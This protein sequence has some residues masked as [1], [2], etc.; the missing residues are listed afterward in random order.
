MGSVELSGIQML[1][2]E[3]VMSNVGVAVIVAVVLL[4]LYVAAALTQFRQ[5]A[6]T[7]ERH[8]LPWQ[9]RMAQIRRSAYVP[10]RNK[11]EP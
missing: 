9:M 1:T 7:P 8:H 5:S 4:A 11:G 6:A 2:Q 3:L 10:R